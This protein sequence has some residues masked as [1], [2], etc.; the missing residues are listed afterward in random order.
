MNALTAGHTTIKLGLPAAEHAR[1]W[2]VGATEAWVTPLGAL[3][4]DE[5][6]DDVS[7]MARES[8]RDQTTVAR[9]MWRVLAGEALGCRPESVEIERT[10]FGHPLPAGLPRT[11]ADLSVSQAG[12]MVL[13][14]SAVGLRLGVDIQRL[15]GL[16]S[17]DRVAQAV[18]GIVGPALDLIPDAME[19]S[20][21]RWCVFEA[22]VKADGRGM[23]LDP[24]VVSAE[25][26]SLWG[27][28]QARVAG[29]LWWVRRLAVPE[30]FVASIA[31]GA[32]VEDLE[33]VA[34][35]ASPNPGPIDAG[36]EAD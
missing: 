9:G 5:E 24:G 28:N 29:T 12:G 6:R 32:P 11:K 7:R 25:V 10:P 26:R 2:L 22:L 15:S 18:E 14:A 13:V 35:G 23:H 31:A 4:S 33:V 34:M 8:D 19:R 1:A 20:V 17:D 30:R 36:L 16:A 27:W 21:F 3:L